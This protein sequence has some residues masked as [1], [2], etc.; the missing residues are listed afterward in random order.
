LTVNLPIKLKLSVLKAP[1][2][3]TRAVVSNARTWGNKVEG[4]FI[5]PGLISYQD[6]GQGVALL[7]KETIDRCVR[8][9]EAKP[10]SIRH[11]AEN[12]FT[13]EKMGD[14]Q[15]DNQE[16]V[17]VGYVSEIYFNPADG[18][19]WFKGTV[20]NDAAKDKIEAGWGVSCTYVP[21]E[22]PGPGGVLNGVRYD[23]E[24]RGF[25]G[26]SIAIEPKGKIRYEGAKISIVRNAKPNSGATTMFKFFKK[27]SLTDIDLQKAADLEEQSKKAADEA[28]KI[29]NAQAEEIELSAETLVTV[30]DKGTQAPFGE[31]AAAYVG[32]VT[33]AMTSIDP[34]TEVEYCPGKSAKMGV[35]CARYKQ[36]MEEDEAKSKN[37]KDEE[38]KKEAAKKHAAE[39]EEK[40]KNAEAEKAR[41]AHKPDHF[42][43]LQHASYQPSA[44]PAPTRKT[45]SNS[46]E[47]QKAR[48]A[49]A[50]GQPSTN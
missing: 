29:R 6:I 20:H 16:L 4:R 33:N 30:D 42:I 40:K 11:D 34:E 41:N 14:P 8:T 49:K 12:V 1:S 17:A 36:A 13:G 45:S 3:T 7:T 9:F 24:T 25:F 5:L 37:A 10:F 38:E 19:Y 48:G 44:T 2:V 26:E 18:W 32:R 43:R 47:A 31:V 27:K 23:Y 28:K 35:M 21:T 22:A 15:P 50:W 46:I 39:E